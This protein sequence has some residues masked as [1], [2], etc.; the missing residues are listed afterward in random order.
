VSSTSVRVGFM[1]GCSLL[2]QGNP[3][4]RTLAHVG[5]MY[6][7]SVHLH[8]SSTSVHVGFMCGCSLLRQGNPVAR[9]LAHVDL[10]SSYARPAGRTRERK[11]RERER[12]RERERARERMHR[13]EDRAGGWSRGPFRGAVTKTGGV[14][15]VESTTLTNSSYERSH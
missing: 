5:F 15:H 11:K 10:S 14:Y 3:V 8:V 9:T 4:A 6:G 7:C 12:E 13:H 2:R 1:C